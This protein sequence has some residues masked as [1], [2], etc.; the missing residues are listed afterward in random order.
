[1]PEE[2]P[3]EVPYDPEG[4][5]ALPTRRP[6]EAA[7]GLATAGVPG[8]AAERGLVSEPGSEPVPEAVPDLLPEEARLVASWDR[9]LGALAD[10]LRR[11]RATVR[12]V[13][14]PAALTA[15]QLLRLAADPEGLARDLA[16]PMPRPPAPAARRGTR[17]HAW[18]ESRFD[19]RPLFGPED[20]PG[21]E[22]DDDIADERDLAALKDAFLRTPYADRTPY[23]V[24]FPFHLV[25]AGRVVRGRM[26]AVYRDGDRYEILDWKTGRVAAADPLQLAVYRLAWS[27]HE[28][29]PL[30]RVTAAFL[31]VRTAEVIRPPDLPDRAALERLLAPEAPDAS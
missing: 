22:G 8:Q 31:H 21:I 25:L 16:R 13:P 4:W 12:D 15:T 19:A 7:P 27:E 5:D 1:V 29:V 30:D 6:A 11:A 28:G 9:D 26:D 2:V 20:L 23:R 10:E 17:F 24:E 18:V 3:D 14:L